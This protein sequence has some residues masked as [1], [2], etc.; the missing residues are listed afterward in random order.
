MVL[1]VIDHVRQ[2]FSADDGAKIGQI[3]T[4]AFARGEKVQLSFAG[5][6]DVTSS[7]VNA[8]VVSQLSAFPVDWVKHHLAIRDVSSPSADVIRRCMANGER[9]MQAA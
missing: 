4:E 3:L 5:I 6:S 9:N 2:C 7:F 8:A 1:K